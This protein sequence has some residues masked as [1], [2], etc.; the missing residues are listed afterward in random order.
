MA[1]GIRGERRHHGVMGGPWTYT[2]DGHD[3]DGTNGADRVLLRV[4]SQYITAGRGRNM[5]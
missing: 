5:Y 2:D 3:T 1:L 4:D